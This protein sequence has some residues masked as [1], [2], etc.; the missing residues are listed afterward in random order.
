MK[1][2]FS[3]IIF[4][5]FHLFLKAVVIIGLSRFLHIFLRKLRQPRVIAE[6]LG[7]ICLGPS[8]LGR[9]PGFSSTLFPE[10]S[11]KTLTLVANIGLVFYLF[12][13]GLELDPKAFVNNFRKS[14]L[15]SMAGILLP[16]LV[17]IGCSYGLY[18]NMLVPNSHNT[19][20]GSFFLFTGVAMSITVNI[21]SV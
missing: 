19:Q 4:S 7:G 17:G 11:L 2:I 3:C 16:F 5:F 10:S 21:Y 8:L 12:L 1:P 9:I 6:M 20:F 15:I 14:L 18:K 13:V